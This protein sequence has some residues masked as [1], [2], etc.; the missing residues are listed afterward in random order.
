MRIL[1][2]EA[3]YGGSHRD[4]ADGIASHSRHEVQLLTLPAR[5]WKWRM[6]GAG[7]TFATRINEELELRSFDLIVTGGM[8][9]ITDVKSLT[10]TPCPPVLLYA[11]ETQLVYPD[12]LKKETDLHFAFTDLTNMLAADRILFNSHTH[13]VAFLAA[14][15]AFLRRLPEHRPT[16]ATA[17]I[18]ARSTVCHPGIHLCPAAGTGPDEPSPNQ[19]PL[20]LW[21]HRWEHDKDP[22]AFLEALSLVKAGGASFKLA[23]LGENFQMVPKPFLEARERFADEIVH[24]GF[25]TDRSEYQRWLLRAD[26]VVSTAIQENFGIAIMEAMAHGALPLVPARLSYPE[27]VPDGYHDRLLYTT[28]KDLA[29]RLIGLLR[30]PD[31]L[32]ALK[33]DGATLM[34]HARSFAWEERIREFDSVFAAVASGG[35]NGT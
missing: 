4:V 17:A 7:I 1:Y 32:K 6:R 31:V 18:S 19:P 14:L 13:R 16:W 2:L 28:T 26:I 20:V 10:N 33:E 3:F 5:F 27:I 30:D 12:L 34:A 29:D 9:S 15:P 22:E 25:V 23:L 35:T 21:N 8:M 24:Y 11:H